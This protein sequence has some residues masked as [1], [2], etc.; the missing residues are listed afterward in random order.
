MARPG[1]S[2]RLTYR[3]H[4]HD[5]LHVC[6]YQEKGSIDTPFELAIRN[7]I[8]RFSIAIEAIDRVPSLKVVGAHGRRACQG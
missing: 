5:N 3:R 7:G 8:D 2:R 4:N 1:S 6:G